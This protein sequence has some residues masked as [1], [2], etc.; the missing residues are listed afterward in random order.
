M[1]YDKDNSGK[2]DQKEMNKFL[3]EFLALAS[4]ERDL[5]LDAAIQSTKEMLAHAKQT[6]GSH[7]DELENSLKVCL[8]ISLSRCYCSLLG[9]KAMIGPR[10]SQGQVG[11]SR[12][13]CG[14]AEGTH[15]NMCFIGFICS[16]SL[17][18]G[19]GCGRQRLCD[20]R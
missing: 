15:T 17:S 5:Q 6:P 7:I 19:A 2:L 9:I 12:V 3:G 18:Q 16:V 4:H 8:C 1:H 13:L 11:H 14:I 20:I 10:S